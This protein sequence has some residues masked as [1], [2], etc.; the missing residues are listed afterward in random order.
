MQ[1]DRRRL[2]TGAAV[3]AVGWRNAAAEES[4]PRSEVAKSDR[5]RVVLLGTAGGPSPK[6]SRSAPASMVVAGG[7][8]YVVDCGNGVARQIVRAGFAL[9]D[10][11]SIFIT[12]QHSDHN[13]DYG[14]LFYLAWSA[15]LKNAVNSYAPPPLSAMTEKF[16]ELNEFDI[17]LRIHDEGRVDPRKLLLPHEIISSGLVMQDENVKVTCALVDHPPIKVALAYRFDTP[18][19][20]IVFSGDTRKCDALIDL[21]RGADVLVCEGQFLPGIRSLADRI[22]SEPSRRDAIYKSISGNALSVQQAGEVA[23]EAGVK[24][25]VINHLVPGDDTVPE[26]VWLEAARES[27]S[28]EVIIGRDLLEI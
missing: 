13:L 22:A 11:K 3:M 16:F 5:A 1:L 27:F 20:S 21:A 17:D 15:A 19:R 28:G 12:H 23:R 6:I 4:S 14:N 9:K 24:T 2:L 10:L 25:L 7:S 26:Y 8:L 18:T